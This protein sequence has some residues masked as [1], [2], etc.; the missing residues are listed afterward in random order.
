MWRWGWWGGGVRVVVGGF[1]GVGKGGVFDAFVELGWQ[2][3]G[4]R[5]KG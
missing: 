1:K 3:G 4:G 2:W 5:G